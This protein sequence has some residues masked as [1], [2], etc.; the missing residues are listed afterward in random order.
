MSYYNHTGNRRSNRTAGIPPPPQY[1]E[2]LVQSAMSSNSSNSSINTPNNSEIHSNASVNMNTYTTPYRNSNIITNTQTDPNSTTAAGINIIQTLPQPTQDTTPKIPMTMN[3]PSK[4]SSGVSYESSIVIQELQHTVKQLQDQLA[5]HGI[6]HTEPHPPYKPI[7]T[8]NINQQHP[9]PTWPPHDRKLPME[10]PSNQPPIR[11]MNTNYTQTFPNPTPLRKTVHMYAPSEH[12]YSFPFSPHPT[13]ESQ[14]YPP[15]APT[16]GDLLDLSPPS[17]HSHAQIAHTILPNQTIAN[18]HPQ[19]MQMVTQFKPLTFRQLKDNKSLQAYKIW[20][21]LCLLEISVHSD[22]RNVIHRTIDGQLSMS[23]SLTEMQS[24]SIYL[25]T[26]KAIGESIL[27]MVDPNQTSLGQGQQLWTAIDDYYLS[28]S[29]T[30]LLKHETLRDE[31]KAITKNR[32]ETFENYAL[33]Y[34]EKLAMLH[35]H[36]VEDAPNG[37]TLAYRLI[38]GLCLP[39]VF[40][41]VLKDINNGV[42]KS[43]Y[44]QT[45][46]HRNLTCI[47]IV[48]KAKEYHDMDVNFSQGYNSPYL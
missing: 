36:Q 14:Q 7:Q 48:K 32:N 22:F 34:S 10:I 15:T 30:N 19:P 35:H 9:Q 8:N 13:N 29:D 38:R 4:S 20:K 3:P 1:D 18:T 40:K 27:K 16:V 23:N 31:L 25:A 21:S 47:Q 2:A 46:T 11:V 26:A 43:W 44:Q 37:A 6:R 42:D 24:H 12:T 39:D 45:G 5:R 17:H 41:P 28:N 33:R